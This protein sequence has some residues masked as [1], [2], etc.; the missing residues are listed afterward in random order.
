MERQK[1]QHACGAKQA[2]GVSREILALT[3]EECILI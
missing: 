2:L 3:D 1:P